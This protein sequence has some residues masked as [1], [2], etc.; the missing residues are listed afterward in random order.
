MISNLKPADE[1]LHIRE[2]IKTL[3]VRESD[4]KD[5]FKKGNLDKHGDYA[6]V[7]VQKRKSKKFNRKAAEAVVGD[8]TRFDEVSESIVVRCDALESQ[9]TE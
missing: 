8:L 4:L 5:G 2:Q 9:P 1:L 3:Q 7:L 6:I